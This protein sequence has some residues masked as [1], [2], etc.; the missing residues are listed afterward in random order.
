MSSFSLSRLFISV[1]MVAIAGCSGAVTVDGP[2][3]EADDGNGAVAPSEPGLHPSEFA[4]NVGAPSSSVTSCAHDLCS[5]GEALATGCDPC[6]DQICA[7]DSFCCQGTWDSM[8]MEEVGSICG[9]PCPIACGN[10]L[11]E[12][13]EDCSTCSQDCGACPTC[14]DNICQWGEDCSTCSQDCG[15]CPTCGDG[16]CDSTETCGTCTQ[17]CGACVCHDKCVD[18]TPLGASCGQC[19]AQICAVDPF[20]CQI[21]WDFLC[22]NEVASVCGETCP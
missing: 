19:E 3:E 12:A 1:A 14:G 15:A 20:C 2:G 13:G 18:G 22:V 16:T 9:Q 7:V 21:A 6:V 10:S 5:I 4:S 11:C 17:D 8:C